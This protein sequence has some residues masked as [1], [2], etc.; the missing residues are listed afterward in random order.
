MKTLLSIT[1][2]LLTFFS[3]G[4]IQ[5]NNDVWCDLSIAYRPAAIAI[6]NDTG[7]LNSSI[8]N[9]NIL[10]MSYAGMTP[11][12]YKV[13]ISGRGQATLIRDSI[14]IK[15]G[16]NLVLSFTFNGPC[17]FDHP[18]NYVPTCPKNHTDSII[19]ILYG[20]VATRGD[21]FVE[22]KKGMKFKYAGCV[23][24]GCDPQFYCKEHDI[25]F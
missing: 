12:K 14:I 2:I 9:G 22:D 5:K 6:S 20:L 4:Q 13:Q 17:L 11:G 15:K 3:L 8:N 23:T 16:Q 21:T 18:T 7:I 25:E 1:F 10:K 19:S 24:T